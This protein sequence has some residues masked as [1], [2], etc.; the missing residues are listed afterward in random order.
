MYNIPSSDITDGALLHVMGRSILN[1]L[2]CKFEGDEF[3]LELL[4]GIAHSVLPT[5]AS[6][7]YP[8]TF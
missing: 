3:L 8:H 6:S 2:S 1:N 5:M 7:Y 4:T